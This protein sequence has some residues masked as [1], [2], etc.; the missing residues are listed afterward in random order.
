MT[1]IYCVEGNI[2]SGKTTLLSRIAERAKHSNLRVKVLEEP[3]EEWNK[4]MKDGKTIL[5]LFYEDPKQYSFDFQILVY[6]S[7]YDAIKKQAEDCDILICERSLES[8]IHIFSQMLYDKG[9]IS[10]VQFGIL[11]F[12][13]RTYSIPTHKRVYLFTPFS[14]CFCRLRIRNRTGEEDITG[15]YLKDLQKYHRN[16]FEKFP[17]NALLEN[18]KDI[19]AFI[20]TVFNPLVF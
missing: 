17:Y 12:M 9:W 3:I 2:S 15:D 7:L 14:I 19:S 4:I 16:F 10:S 1:Y 18:D 11:E 6:M 8:N 5:Q 13:S 20:D